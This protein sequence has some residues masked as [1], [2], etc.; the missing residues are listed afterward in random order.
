MAGAIDDLDACACGIAS[1]MRY[2]MSTYFRSSPPAISSVGIRSSPS[3]G[4]L[5]G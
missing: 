4:Q 2:A 3:R 5:F 1:R